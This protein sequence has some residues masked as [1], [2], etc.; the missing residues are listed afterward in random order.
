M[1]TKLYVGP[2][3]IN[4]IRAAAEIA[5]EKNI[6]I[7]LIASRNQIDSFTH[8]GGYV[9][10]FT[11]EMYVKYLKD[12]NL[13]Q[14]FILCRDHGGPYQNAREKN[15]NFNEAMNLAK[16]SYTADIQNGFTFLHIDPSVTPGR[17]DINDIITELYLVNQSV[18]KTE[19]N[20]RDA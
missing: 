19:S 8:G 4:T 20:P 18:S 9:N 10:N 12:Y 7:P 2:V 3:S 14:Y 13:D 6:K 5:K 15:L 1:R 16:S 17:T 11:T